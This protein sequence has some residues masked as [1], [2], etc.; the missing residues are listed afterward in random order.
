MVSIRFFIYGLT[1]HLDLNEIVL[2]M[3]FGSSESLYC[4]DTYQYKDYSKVVANRFDAEKKAKRRQEVFPKDCE[5]AFEM[6]V[7]FAKKNG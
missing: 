6:G 5:K 3:I 2:R 7:R 4:F 1:Q